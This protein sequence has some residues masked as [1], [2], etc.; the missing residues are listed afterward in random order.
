MKLEETN[1]IIPLP[2][3]HEVKDSISGLVN[4]LLTPNR[5]IEVSDYNIKADGDDTCRLWFVPETGSEQKA[6][7]F[8]ENKPSRILAMIS[9]LASGNYRVKFVTQFG[10]SSTSLKTYKT[11]IYPKILTVG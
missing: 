9:A 10:G 3:I 6:T 2:Q 4:E 7:I 11:Y 5:V 1:I 8:I